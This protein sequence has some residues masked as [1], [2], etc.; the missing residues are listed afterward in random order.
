VQGVTLQ[1]QFH[2]LSRK[3]MLEAPVNFDFRWHFATDEPSEPLTSPAHARTYDTGTI[4]SVVRPANTL[5]SL[6]GTRPHVLFLPSTRPL[7]CLL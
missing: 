7:S 6:L 3:E 4:H 2:M 1:Q 5:H